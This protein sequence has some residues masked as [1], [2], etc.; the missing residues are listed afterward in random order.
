MLGLSV[1][2][3]VMGMSANS[4]A[5]VIGAM[6]LA[7]LM[8][9]VL[10][11]AACISMALFRKSLT[12]AGH[13]LL[14]SIGSIA[15]AYVLSALFVNGDL[16]NEVTSRTAPDI[17]DLIVALGAGTAGA[18]ATVR[19]DVSSSLPGVAVAVALVPPLAAVGITLEAGRETLA[20]GALLLYAT[21][22]VAIVLA[23]SIVFVATGFVPPR[24][25]ATT[26]RR[27]AAVSAV[28]AIA[29]IAIAI[30]L[31]RASVSAV[32]AT[33]RQL[34]ASAIVDDWL[35]QISP[36]DPPS[37]VFN[38]QRILVRV[39]SF[40]DPV[41]DR[42]LTDALQLQFGADRIV[43]LEWEKLARFETTT[44]IAPTTTILSDAQ[45]LADAVETIVDDWL[46][47]GEFEGVRRVDALV[48]G[49][50]VVRVDASGVGDAPPVAGPHVAA[51]RT[52]RRDT[53]SA[54]DVGRAAQR[55]ER[56]RPHRRPV[57]HRADRRPRR[58]M[59]T[60]RRR[61]RSLSVEYDG[62][63]WRSFEVAG[64]TPP[65]ATDL[66]DDIDGPAARRGNGQRVV[67]PSTRHHDDHDHDHDHDRPIDDHDPVSDLTELADHPGAA[68][69]EP[70]AGPDH[71]MRRL[72]AGDGIRRG[73]DQR[74]GGPGPGDLRRHGVGVERGPRRPDQGRTRSRTRSTAARSPSM[75]PG[76]RWA[77]GPV[78]A[79]ACSP[80]ASD[81]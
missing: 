27:T 74:R 58:G 42:P 55:H 6:L 8:Q 29:V 45:R 67:R 76:S 25:L 32:E 30:P 69:P 4:A 24:R 66:V 2:V 23:A 70:F 17:R 18:Y 78:Q 3:A 22:L 65:D 1:V 33:D 38:D 68:N 36:A 40:E 10:A 61:R 75:A 72:D 28:V 77:R 46:Q 57:D 39:R 44:T 31:Y 59:G 51:R 19:K 79:P 54:A 9:P 35:G 62:T 14:A 52:T 34:E 5:V 73:L 48:I 56:H 11:T 16:P 64:E 15:L 43:S 60:G 37:I 80:R 53:R 13:V 26:F 47:A 49:G 20:R 41:D 71:P 12:A 7:P 81:S 63:H 50:G 21:N